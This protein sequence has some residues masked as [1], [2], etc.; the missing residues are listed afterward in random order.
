M[1][2]GQNNKSKTS[3]K[4]KKRE[5]KSK[6]QQINI[7]VSNIDVGSIY[8]DQISYKEP[9][10]PLEIDEVVEDNVDLAGNVYV[11]Y[12]D[13]LQEMYTSADIKGSFSFD[14]QKID[15]LVSRI[16][17]GSS[18]KYE[19]DSSSSP[20][21]DPNI[22]T[23]GGPLGEIKDDENIQ[24]ENY[25]DPVVIFGPQIEV[26]HIA[27]SKG[28]APDNIQEDGTIN[29]DGV[30]MSPTEDYPIFVKEGSIIPMS[31]DLNTKPSFYNHS[32]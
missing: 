13:I 17:S 28:S 10:K 1:P 26:S 27:V 30:N 15:A 18:P 25:T 3:S 23:N 7:P 20:N 12:S 22:N 9:I 2:T 21:T 19:E 5:V 6:I 31:L 8:K 4:T 16:I 29:T 32:Y 11:T 24:N 14:P